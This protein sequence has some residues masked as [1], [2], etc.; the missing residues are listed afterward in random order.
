MTWAPLSVKKPRS[1]DATLRRAGFAR[2]VRIA[3]GIEHGALV[4]GVTVAIGRCD[5]LTR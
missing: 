1:S 5:D 2:M 4:L 3:D